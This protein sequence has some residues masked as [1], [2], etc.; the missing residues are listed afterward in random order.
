MFK[1]KVIA[2]I[3]N[4]HQGDTST[5][6]S[7]IKA[8]ACSGADGVKFQWFKYDHLATEDYF[9]YKSYQEMFIPENEWQDILS[10]AKKLGVEV[11][12]DI[13]DDWG[14]ELAVKLSSMIDGFK[15]P[16]T[17]IQ[18]HDIIEGIFSFQKP[19]LLGVGGWYEHEIDAFMQS[20]NKKNLE[21]LIIIHGFQGYPTNTEDANLIRIGY[22]KNRYNLQVGFADHEDASEQLAVDLPIYALFAGATLIEKHIILDRSKKGY[23]YY[24]ALEP[25]E[26]SK[27]V[28]KLRE[29]ELAIGT[30]DVND[31]ERNYLKDTLRVIAKKDIKKGEI[32]T[33]NKTVYKRCSVAKALMPIE[34][35]EKGPIIAKEQIKKNQPVI[36]DVLEQPKII[37]AVVCRLKSTR[38]PKKALLPINGVA[39]I[40]RCLLNC[41]AVP[42]VK[43]VILAT[44]YLA[45]DDPL[46]QF[47]VNGKVK[48]F[49]GDPD[50]VARRLIQVAHETGANIVLRVTGD[51]P[52]VSPEI[53]NILIE[54]HLKS[55]M[56]LTIP[57][58]EHAVGTAAD[59]YTVE[60]LNRLLEQKKPLTHT[61]YLSFYYINNPNIFS[62]NK[63]EMPDEFRYPQWRLTLDEQKDL[64][65][66]EAIYSNLD[67]K[68]EP[69]FFCKLR[70]YLLNNPQL[71]ASNSEV[72]LKWKDN[73]EICKE[74]SE[75]TDLSKLN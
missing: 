5:L 73:Q 4:A 19:V 41:L 64:E 6:Y 46:E 42:N 36:S 72:P 7:L 71:T 48:V 11:W 22:L 12:I 55:G 58:S 34:F 16:S 63:V 51:C 31:S 44:S 8:A 68:R 52:A 24:S 35:K 40:E 1:V 70:D 75:A 45:E 27:M 30:I 23:D 13:F 53:L 28:S 14:L 17:I 67:I 65:L 57:T 9:F 66:L 29:A 18:A 26:F 39:S 47:T 20:L 69:L 37:I 2:E 33:L 74:I 49:R 43:Q 61:E 60:S 32:L 50:N 62:V 38:L 15:I 56:D 21:N 59:V 10:F 25:D 3:A 54:A